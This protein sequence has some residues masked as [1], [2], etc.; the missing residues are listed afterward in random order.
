M[1]GNSLNL[2]SY[3]EDGIL[4]STEGIEGIGIA[5]SL[6]EGRTI[7]VQLRDFCM[8]EVGSILE[9]F[10]GP[11]TVF[12]EHFIDAEI[13]IINSKRGELLFISHLH[14]LLENTYL[15]EEIHTFFLG[16]ILNNTQRSP[17]KYILFF[18]LGS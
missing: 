18:H 13:P 7:A 2:A 16:E 3:D 10:L 11:G 15:I 1:S 4:I 12:Q 8:M 5:L 9:R 17:C 6:V 14:R